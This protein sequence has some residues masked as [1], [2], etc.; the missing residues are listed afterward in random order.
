MIL[1]IGTA[2]LWSSQAI[3]LQRPIE[4]L[5]V[6]G[7]KW[8][9][10]ESR[11]IEGAVEFDIYGNELDRPNDELYAIGSKWHLPYDDLR[12]ALDE[13][14]TPDDEMADDINVVLPSVKANYNNDSKNIE[15]NQLYLCEYTNDCSAADEVFQI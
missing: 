4:L 14:Q 15:K 10:Y 7:D 1:K 3:V 9:K 6:D 12:K 5:T 13:P 2:L 11:V 8:N